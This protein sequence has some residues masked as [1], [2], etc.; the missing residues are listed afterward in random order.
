MLFC[1]VFFFGRQSYVVPPHVLA[2]GSPSLKYSW[3]LLLTSIF[4]SI[5]FQTVHML[6]MCNPKIVKSMLSTYLLT[7]T[8]CTYILRLR[9]TGTKPS[10][11]IY[12]TNLS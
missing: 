3:H 2:M 9:I 5:F 8:I 7:G 12:R 10:E 1:F 11:K 6:S 4:L